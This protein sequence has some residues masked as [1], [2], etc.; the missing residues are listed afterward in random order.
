[1]TQRDP[2]PES[3]AEHVDGVRRLARHLVRE[4]AAADDVAQEALLTASERRPRAGWGLASWLR[5]LV[6]N[7]AREQAR[8]EGRRRT[9][10]RSLPPTP[11]VP[12]P[13][14][15]VARVEVHK[16]VLNAV[17]ALPDPYRTVVWLRY[18][19]DRGPRA[20]ARLLEVPHETVRTHLKRGLTRLRARLD[21][22]DPG[23]AGAWRT[24]LLPLLGAPPRWPGPWL[25]EALH[26]TTQ[27][28]VVLTLSCAGTLLL[29]VWGLGLLPLGG[30]GVR[31]GAPAGLDP[32]GRP[33]AHS[34]GPALEGRG[35]PTA[36]EGEEEAPPAVDL[37]AADRQRD[38]HGIVVRKDGTPVA[39]A[40]LTAWKRRWENG[41]LFTLRDEKEEVG[42]TRSSL[43][44]SFSLRL[45]PGDVVDLEVSAAS[46]ATVTL[47]RRNAGERTRVVLTAGTDLGVTIVNQRGQP[48]AG[49]P[50]RLFRVGRGAGR[51]DVREERVSDGAGSAWF[52]GLLGGHALTLEAK[53]PDLGGSGWVDV[54]LPEE[55]TLLRTLTLPDGRTVRGQVTEAQTR[56]PVAGASVGEN[57]TGRHAVVT[58]AEGRYT[59]RGWTAKGTE[60]LTAFAPGYVRVLH[61]VGD[62]DE[63]NF[64][65]TRGA[66]LLGRV[67]TS[68]GRPLAGAAVSGNAFPQDPADNLVMGFPSAVTDAEGAFV[69]EGVARVHELLFAVQA[70][71]WGTHTETVAAARLV[72]GD[73]HLGDIRL[74]SERWLR[75]V[76]VDAEGAPV[77]RVQ[78][79]ASALRPGASASDRWARKGQLY[80]VGGER[81]TDDL[82]RFAFGGLVP[83]TYRLVVRPDGQGEIVVEALVPEEGEAAEV[84]LVVP[85]VR[86]L[87]VEVVT[88]EGKPVE[89]L[90]V[91]LQGFTSAYHPG[92]TTD[93]RGRASLRLSADVRYVSLGFP[94]DAYDRYAEAGAATLT[95][96]AGDRSLRF[97]LEECQPALG[98]VIDA[99]GAPVANVGVEALLA[100]GR[101][102]SRRMTDASGEFR[103]PVPKGRTVTLAVTGSGQQTLP[104][105]ATAL[106]DVA[107]E[108]RLEGVGAGDRDLV[109]TVRPRAA[110]RSLV[111]QVLAPDGA[112]AV[113]A[114]VA[115]RITSMATVS[116]T[117]D[118]SGRVRLEPLPDRPVE[119]RVDPAGMRRAPGLPPLAA[120]RRTGVTPSEHPL[121]VLL[122]P[123]ATLLG[124]VVD[125]RGVGLTDIEVLALL[126]GGD[127]RT[128]RSGP[129]GRFGIPLHPTAAFPLDVEATHTS[130]K[131]LLLLG[132]LHVGSS[133]D[134]GDVTLV[135]RRA[136]DG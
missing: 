107:L 115:A 88:T 111:V 106:M 87:E 96:R 80:G 50:V 118:E 44:G 93:A 11:P 122:E 18:F 86:I 2:E 58:D 89:G 51:E 95:L 37:A 1:M 113:G 3:L 76:V 120:E 126:P 131:G 132:T 105:G 35:K 45:R 40:R 125:E 10:E 83:G 136:K 77:A 70:A 112:P 48:V 27:S 33:E 59:Y 5:G 64:E 41:G 61:R 46:L 67:L 127:Q 100:D 30:A 39:G 29:A 108:G 14:D 81:N 12:S 26:V 91:H 129:D 23:G 69:L 66:R 56:Q 103:C 38:L 57:W 109:L 22:D 47:A 28:K 31:A 13:A 94:T 84:Q 114:R 55:G 53:H 116:G 78:V 7:K 121:T 8:A 130:P 17:L 101:V 90:F 110:D 20:I 43:D 34:A 63:V 135:L 97:V 49:C 21:T 68:D 85:D 65:L 117:T 16:R 98:R 124:R 75:G 73:V 128:G 82:G 104:G 6:R 133:R 79:F 4:R 72:E 36:S 15:M 24:A 60:V 25:Q 92:A 52:R 9:R 123:C 62:L 32:S 99:Q 19:E 54:S 102:V 119:V 74:T 42:R 134:A 71:G